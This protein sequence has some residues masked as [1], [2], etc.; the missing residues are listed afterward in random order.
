MHESESAGFL[1]WTLPKVHTW[2]S[3]IKLLFN[4]FMERFVKNKIVFQQIYILLHFQIVIWP[5]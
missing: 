5:G 3:P 1:A 4:F 2:S